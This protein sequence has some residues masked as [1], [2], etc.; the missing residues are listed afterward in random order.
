LRDFVS[1][2]VFRAF[3]EGEFCAFSHAAGL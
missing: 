3:G 1:V 2:T